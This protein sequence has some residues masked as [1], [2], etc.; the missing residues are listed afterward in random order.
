MSFW[1]PETR[2]RLPQVK[3]FFKVPP[4]RVK[5]LATPSSILI[6][7][8]TGELCSQS[9]RGNVRRTGRM[10]LE[11]VERSSSTNT[12]NYIH[13][14]N[15]RPLMNQLY[16][17][18]TPNYVSAI[19]LRTGFTVSVDVKQHWTVLRHWLQ[20]VR[21]MSTDI[22]EQWSSTSPP[23]PRQ[24]FGQTPIWSGCVTISCLKLRVPSLLSTQS[25]GQTPIWSGCVTISV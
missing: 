19:N 15:V 7:I 5:Y 22:R 17:P 25:F 9:V 4:K 3:F 23:L 2:L 14:A 20:F 11:H 8:S 18:N 1:V 16:S 10:F 21:N 13:E 24:S 12:P 6:L